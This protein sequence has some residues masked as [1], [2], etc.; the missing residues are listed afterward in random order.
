MSQSTF[1][2]PPNQSLAKLQDKATCQ[3]VVNFIQANSTILLNFTKDIQMKSKFTPLQMA[4]MALV[5]YNAVGHQH[6]VLWAKGKMA[7]F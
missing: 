1:P 2:L 7:R 3:K 5:T 6:K 4:F